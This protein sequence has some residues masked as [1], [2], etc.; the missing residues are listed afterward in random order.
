MNE[1]HNILP[2]SFSTQR[3]HFDRR[4]M[5]LSDNRKR[6]L[7][8]GP[9]FS[10]YYYEKFSKIAQNNANSGFNFGAFFLGF[11][12]FFYR[13][14]YLYGCLAILLMLL[15]TAISVFLEI[16]GFIVSL[17]VLIFFA[18][19]ANSIYKGFVDKKI[20]QI[21]SLEIKDLEYELMKRGR[22]SPVAVTTVVL[23]IV[24]LLAFI[25]RS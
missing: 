6:A 18:L 14:M 24:I 16:K 12:W 20:R 3:T 11:L 10:S 1:H 7:F 4:G 22:T 8:I 21:E 15:S 2:P 9:K 5:A 13:K 17:P 25:L 23:C 19:Y